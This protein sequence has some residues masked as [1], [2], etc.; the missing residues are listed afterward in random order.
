MVVYIY[1]QIYL[2]GAKIWISKW[3]IAVILP[4]IFQYQKKFPRPWVARSRLLSGLQQFK[5]ASG[6]SNCFSS[7]FDKF[8]QETIPKKKQLNLGYCPNR[9][10]MWT[11]YF[12]LHK[13]FCIRGIMVTRR[14]FEGTDSFYSTLARSGALVSTG[15]NVNY[16]LFIAQRILYKGNYGH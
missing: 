16:V 6:T 5:L 13:E 11:M 15:D 3:K 12:L 10:T 7:L 2:N 4:G 14:C 1:F 8:C 9:G